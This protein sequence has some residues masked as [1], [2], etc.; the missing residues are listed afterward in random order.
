MQDRRFPTSAYSARPAENRHALGSDGR[1]YLQGGKG[2]EDVGRLFG[3]MKEREALQ[4][5]QAVD[6]T[7]IMS[8]GQSSPWHLRKR[9]TPGRKF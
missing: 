4:K 9:K 2:K 1:S 3:D 7:M 5:S 8:A 6:V